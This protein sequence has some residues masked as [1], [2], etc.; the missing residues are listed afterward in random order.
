MIEFV[1]LAAMLVL[2]PVPKDAPAPEV[3]IVPIVQS[4]VVARPVRPAYTDDFTLINESAGCKSGDE[5]A[6]YSFITKT[7]ADR[8]TAIKYGDALDTATAACK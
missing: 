6:C 2:H 7:A 4:C 3:K 8:S 1:I 5:K